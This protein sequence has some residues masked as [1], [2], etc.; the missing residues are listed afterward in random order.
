MLQHIKVERRSTLTWTDCH[1]DARWM[2]L[3]HKHHGYRSGVYVSLG[4]LLWALWPQYRVLTYG[5]IVCIDQI[6]SICAFNYIA[7][8]SCVSIYLCCRIQTERLLCD[9]ERDLLAVAKFLVSSQEPS[10]INVKSC[11]MVDGL[12]NMLVARVKKWRVK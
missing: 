9:A 6:H 8:T 11:L 1:S 3:I 10:A 7:R 2:S 4:H 12:W 5:F